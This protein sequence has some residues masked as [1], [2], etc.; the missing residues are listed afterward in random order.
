MGLSGVAW[1]AAFLLC[2]FVAL[3][4]I[5]YLTGGPGVGNNEPER[6]ANGVGAALVPWVAGCIVLL[7]STRRRP[8]RWVDIGVTLLAMAGVGVTTFGPRLSA[9]LNGG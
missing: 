2:A 7:L 5:A 8:A 3:S 1:R 6:I 4:W 9:A